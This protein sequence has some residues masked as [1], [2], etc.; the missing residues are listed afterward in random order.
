ML[1][2]AIGVLLLAGFLAAMFF[3]TAQEATVTCEVCVEFG[4][5]STC[6]TAS[7]IDRSTAVTG[8]HSTACAVLS[9][10]V[11]QGLQCDR[12]SPRSVRC[13]E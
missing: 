3:A 12:A 2:M 4:G 6:G 5:R 11:T 7:G 13:T 8:A 10:G 1:R 9:G